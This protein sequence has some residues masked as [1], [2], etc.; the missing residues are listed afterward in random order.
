MPQGIPVLARLPRM[1]SAGVVDFREVELPDHGLPDPGDAST[2]ADVDVP[3][4]HVPPPT[5]RETHQDVEPVTTISQPMMPSQRAPNSPDAAAVPEAGPVFRFDPG[6][7]PVSAEPPT[8]ASVNVEHAPPQTETTAP[9]A[10]PS[11]A[12]RFGLRNL[13]QRSLTAVVVLAVLLSIPAYLLLTTFDDP[14]P[15]DGPNLQADG[16]AQLT[17]MQANSAT[18]ETTDDPATPDPATPPIYRSATLPNE[19]RPFAPQFPLPPDFPQQANPTETNAPATPSPGMAPGAT[20]T[21][22]EKRAP[23]GATLM[24][25]RPRDLRAENERNRSSIY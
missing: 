24:G 9:S 13:I 4:E 16:D 20:D 7:P 23:G 12:E 11:T 14:V 17:E 5:P 18:D 10:V 6:H 2:H 1:T 15:H 3:S 22:I 8:A 25:I 19:R 21:N